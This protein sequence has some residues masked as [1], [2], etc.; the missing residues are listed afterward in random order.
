[1]RRGLQPLRSWPTKSG[2][3]AGTKCKKDN[4]DRNASIDNWQSAARCINNEEV[5]EGEKK[6]SEEGG[7]RLRIDL[8]SAQDNTYLFPLATAQSQVS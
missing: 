1:M 2:E 5:Q 8:R 7:H 3:M 6:K 4:Q